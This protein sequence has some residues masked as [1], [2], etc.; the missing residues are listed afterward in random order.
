[1]PA[2]LGATQ[3]G[4][5]NRWL[6]VR[7][8]R[9]VAAPGVPM[10]RS[11]RRNNEQQCVS[12]NGLRPPTPRQPSWR[13]RGP[14]RPGYQT[15][16]CRSRHSRGGGRRTPETT[17][18][19][20]GLRGTGLG[21][22]LRRVRNDSRAPTSTKGRGERENGSVGPV[23]EAAADVGDRPVRGHRAV[24]RR[25]RPVRRGTDPPSRPPPAARC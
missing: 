10:R 21:R 14:R 7:P 15:F 25:A 20:N 22:L 4:A 11:T 2:R 18:D 13:A 23:A 1:L 6:V 5:P 16:V 3:K 19:R 8:R 12:A 24:R 9:S 17:P